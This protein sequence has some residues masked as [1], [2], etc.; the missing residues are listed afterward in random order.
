MTVIKAARSTILRPLR[1]GDGAR[2]LAAVGR[3]EAAR[4]ASGVGPGAPALWLSAPAHLPASEGLC[5]GPQAKFP[6]L[7]RGPA[8]RPQH[9]AAPFAH[10]LADAGCPCR[11]VLAATGP[12]R[13][14]RRWPRALARCRPPL[15]DVTCV[16]YKSPAERKQVRTTN[17][18]E[19]RF[20]KVRR[21]TR[22]GGAPRRTIARTDR[23]ER[24][25]RIF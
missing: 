4:S 9:C 2:P 17:A 21:R 1:T 16:R 18:I 5:L 14:A 3:S 22:G 25:P 24:N 8:A 11:S 6:H 13:L 10:R 19:R 20:R 7:P 23:S 15:Y 12:R